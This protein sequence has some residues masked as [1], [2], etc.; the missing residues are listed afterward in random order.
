MRFTQL[1]S[2]LNGEIIVSIEETL[3]QLVESNKALAEANKGLTA[4]L[5]TLEDCLK[6]LNMP[7]AEQAAETPAQ[8]EAEQAA[9]KRVVEGKNRKR[10]IPEGEPETLKEKMAQRRDTGKPEYQP[11]IETR[12]RVI[13]EGTL[14]E[15]VQAEQIGGAAKPAEKPAEPAPVKAAAPAAKPQAEQAENSYGAFPVQFEHIKECTDQVRVDISAV[16]VPW[17]RHAIT[18]DKKAV[19]AIFEKYS[20]LGEDG[21]PKVKNPTY[22]S[23]DVFLKFVA[24]CKAL[25]EGNG[26]RAA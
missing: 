14:Q 13:A 19:L 11:K 12:S 24:D 16:L 6:G 7:R 1:F 2:A 23:N 15:P 20:G 21:L 4:R 9:K 22:L 18:V 17:V 8:P 3:G 25:G 26:S 5:I 10:Y